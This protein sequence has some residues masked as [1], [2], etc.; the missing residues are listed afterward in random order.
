MLSD[1]WRLLPTLETRHARLVG[2]LFLG[3]LMLAPAAL[4]QET[5][6][7]PA[8]P[9]DVVRGNPAQPNIVWSSTLVRGMSRQRRS[10]TLWRN[11]SNSRHCFVMGWWAAPHLDL[12]R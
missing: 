10:S 12:L 2:L 5:P 4:A 1:S 9:D 8:S 3:M 7:V 6:Q 11:T